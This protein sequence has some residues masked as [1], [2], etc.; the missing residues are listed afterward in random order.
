M[1]LGS[2]K[3]GHPEESFTQGEHVNSSYKGL[4]DSVSCCE[5]TML[6]TAPLRLANIIINILIKISS[7]AGNPRENHFQH[8][9]WGMGKA[10]CF[11]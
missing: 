4:V 6:A 5:A 8:A 11:Y 3:H 7:L 10:Y 1:S 2:R 9:V